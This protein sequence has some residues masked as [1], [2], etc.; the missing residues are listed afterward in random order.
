[1]RIFLFERPPCFS[2]C[3]NSLGTSKSLFKHSPDRSLVCTF[4]L[5]SFHLYLY[6]YVSTFTNTGCD[7]ISKCPSEWWS[8]RAI[9]IMRVKR[10]LYRKKKKFKPHCRWAQRAQS[11]T[12][13][14]TE[15]FGTYNAW[16]YPDEH[17]FHPLGSI[18][19]L[20]CLALQNFKFQT[21][22]SRE[23][24]TKSAQTWASPLM[25]SRPDERPVLLKYTATS[26]FRIQVSCC[27]AH[28]GI[29]C[30]A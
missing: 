6:L 5:F 7:F 21:K 18:N 11:T 8:A 14:R 23:F 28:N 12:S 3:H 4:E 25:N 20:L 29:L 30:T 22:Y 26:Y 10:V 16:I 9:W 19:R 27:V 1:M 13:I 24:V 17:S 15:T 2:W